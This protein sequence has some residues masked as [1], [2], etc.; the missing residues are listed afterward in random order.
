MGSAWT[1]IDRRDHVCKSAWESILMRIFSCIVRKRNVVTPGANTPHS[2]LCL[3]TISHAKQFKRS[4][5][6]IVTH[7]DIT[8]SIPLCHV[9]LAAKNMG[10][11]SNLESQNFRF[12]RIFVRILEKLANQITP[13]DVSTSLTS[14][15]LCRTVLTR[16]IL[17]VWRPRYAKGSV[18]LIA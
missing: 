9:T 16:M 7:Y 8:R 4:L 17:Y 5:P 14:V 11:F 13:S 10:E 6:V 3:S 18:Y 1:A 12:I 2:I 15:N